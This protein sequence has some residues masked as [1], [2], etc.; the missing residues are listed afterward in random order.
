MHQFIACLW[1]PALGVMVEQQRL[2]ELREAPFVLLNGTNRVQAVSSKASEFGVREGIEIAWA[3]ALCPDLISYPLDEEAYCKAAQPA[4]NSFAIES[5]FVEPDG[6]SRC[7]VLMEGGDKV[8]RLT[9]LFRQVSRLFEC[10]A[11]M[12]VG[13]TKLIS[14][15]AAEGKREMPNIISPSAEQAFLRNIPLSEVSNLIM[16]NSPTLEK[17]GLQTFGDV[18]ELPSGSLQRR[19]GRI[20][21]QI[22]RL[23]HGIDGDYVHALWPPHEL[24]T[25]YS[26]E[27][28]T[29][30]AQEVQ[31]ALNELSRQIAACLAIRVEYARCIT[32]EVYEEDATTPTLC[33]SESLSHPAHSAQDICL[34]A[35]RLFGRLQIDRSIS[36]VS[37]LASRIGHVGA[38]QLT[39]LDDNSS[40]Q[41]YPSERSRRLKASTAYLQRKYGEH[42]VEHIAYPASRIRQWVFPLGRKLKEPIQ[43]IT[44]LDGSPNRFTWRGRERHVVSILDL[45][46][47]T[48][49]LKGGDTRVFR[50]QCE[51]FCI[52]EIKQSGNE[53]RIAALAD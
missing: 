5:S 42:I 19:I 49:W 32:L 16:L 21:L 8:E 33:K 38:T 40:L 27:L 13:R 15:L 46:V 31:Q 30:N 4:W 18:C 7:Y 37:L 48:G 29:N 53:W 26:F 3:R 1:M 9:S 2:P 39:L 50:V 20:G 10:G 43:V 34:A 12:G 52:S 44:N 28:A 25:S 41:G 36:R 6:Y 22:E 45:W 23:A 51:P 14:R 11:Y 24:S 35:N 47:E 17:L